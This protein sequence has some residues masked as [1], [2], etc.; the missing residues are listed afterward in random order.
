MDALTFRRMT[1]EDRRDAYGLLRAL[2][3][4]DPLARDTARAY[5]GS[6]AST[7]A[8]AA[9]GQALSLFIERPDYGFIWM[10]YDGTR[11]I[12]C[13][14]VSYA[15]SASAGAVIANLDYLVVIEDRRGEGVGRA[16]LQSLAEHLKFL[17]VARINISVHTE[18]EAA[19]EFLSALGFE[20][21][22]EERMVRGL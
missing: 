12:G 17:D 11:A 20:A 2:L 6:A 14:A 18:N 19:K 3:L 8:E 10:A 22:H 7:D 15:I 9:L 4:G 21:T 1:S 5:R 13:A 16:L